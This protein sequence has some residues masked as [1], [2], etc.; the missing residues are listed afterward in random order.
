MIQTEVV[1]ARPVPAIMSIEAIHDTYMKKRAIR[2]RKSTSTVR[3]H[4][5]AKYLVHEYETVNEFLNSNH[6]IPRYRTI[7]CYSEHQAVA[8][9]LRIYKGAKPLKEC[10][11]FVRGE[12]MGAMAR[13][14]RFTAKNSSK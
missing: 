14:Q 2:R 5:F 3:W 1:A 9:L 13:V 12:K 10:V 6:I 4:P 8:E 11:L 7:V